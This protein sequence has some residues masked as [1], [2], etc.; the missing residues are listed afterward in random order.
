[1]NT[2]LAIA[3]EGIQNEYSVAEHFGRC[4][5][6][7]LY[8]INDENEVVKNEV[9]QN[10][11]AG[12]HGGTCQL[13]HFVNQIGANVIIAGG[14][15]GKAISLFENYGINVITAPG[16]KLED[17]LKAFTEGK[18][19]GYQECEGHQGDCH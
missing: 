13:P 14:M 9:F 19:S 1:M 6:F 16:L 4:E 12:N 11:L 5:Q 2:K 17:A 10:P 7:N 15:G 18:I 3:V 8:E